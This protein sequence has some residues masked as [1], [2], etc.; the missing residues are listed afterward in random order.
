L[1]T[2]IVLDVEER[3]SVA[4]MIDRQLIAALTVKQGGMSLPMVYPEG[5]DTEWEPPSYQIV[6][7]L[8]KAEHHPGNFDEMTE[9]IT[10]R[11]KRI[12]REIY[13]YPD[14]TKVNRAVQI[15]GVDFQELVDSLSY[16]EDADSQ[17]LNVRERLSIKDLLLENIAFEFHKSEPRFNGEGNLIMD[18][19]I[20]RDK[21]TKF[22]NKFASKLLTCPSCKGA[23]STLM[24]TEGAV[25][26]HCHNCPSVTGLHT[27]NIG[28]IA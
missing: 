22:V 11:Q 8:V 9:N 25:Q 2:P 28:Q 5:T 19:F 10:Y 13:A 27:T 21:I 3:N 4:V 18:G 1:K 17:K 7:D 6:D 16:K 26:R 12:R 23:R 24:R 15:N 14:V 20:M